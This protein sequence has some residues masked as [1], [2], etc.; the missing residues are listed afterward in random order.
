MANEQRIALIRAR[1]KQVFPDS[2]ELRDAFIRGAVWTES[3]YW[4]DAVKDKPEDGTVVF[5]AYGYHKDKD[6]IHCGVNVAKYENKKFN[7]YSDEQPD[8]WCYPPM[9]VEKEE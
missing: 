7:S 8:L 9:F 1:A 5:C 3:S 4:M 2:E 6:G